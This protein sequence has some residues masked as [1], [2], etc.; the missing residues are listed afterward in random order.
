MYLVSH[1]KADSLS[2][3]IPM[4]GSYSWKFICMYIVCV[5]KQ[6]KVQN[7]GEIYNINIGSYF[8]SNLYP[9]YYEKVRVLNIHLY[10]SQ[11]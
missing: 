6:K 8:D 2:A 11:E 10:F 5:T 4:Y 9:E 7:L 1:L 3:C